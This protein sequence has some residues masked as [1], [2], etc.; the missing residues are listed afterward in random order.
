MRNGLSA[1]RSAHGCL[2]VITYHK[3][4]TIKRN[5]VF[6][7]RAVACVIVLSGFSMLLACENEI[8]KVEV[9]ADQKE[10]AV[11]TGEDV[12][13]RYSSDGNVRV[14]I[15]APTLKRHREKKP[16]IEFNNGLRVYFYDENRQ[17]DSKLRA[18]Y[19]IAYENRDEMVVRKDVVLI[20]TK[21]EKLNT[22][23]LTWEREKQK[24]YTD[25]FVKIKREDEIIMGEGLVS[26]EKFTE[27]TIKD[28]KG[29]I[30]IESEEFEE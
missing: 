9:V 27:Y 14:K 13:M 7:I 10:A 3:P 1:V 16:Y 4:V 21:G 24:I 28:I 20:N 19:G 15:I 26:N 23:K 5:Q 22:E 12:E 29:T 25:K 2:Q 17:I 18:K 30:N 11:E 8:Q 6:K